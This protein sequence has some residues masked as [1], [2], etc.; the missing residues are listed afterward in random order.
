[1][2]KLNINKKLIYLFFNSIKSGVNIIENVSLNN[3]YLNT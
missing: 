1:M 2:L 3:Y